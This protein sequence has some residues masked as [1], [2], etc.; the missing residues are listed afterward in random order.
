MPTICK[1]TLDASEYR[2]ELERVVQESRAAAAEMNAIK[3][4]QPAVLPQSNKAAMGAARP[5]VQ[6]QTYTVTGT[7]DAPEAREPVRATADHTPAGATRPEVQDQTYT[8]TGTVNAPE[9][10][11]VQDQTYT[12]TGT[13]N[14]PEVP[15]VQDQTYT[16]S[17]TVNAPEVPDVQDQTYTV[18]GTV[19]APEVPEVPDQTCTVTVTAKDNGVQEV[20]KDTE[21]LGKTLEKIP[22]TKFTDQLKG[23]LSAVREAMNKTSGG[24]EKLLETFF[25]GGGAIGIIIAGFA[26]LGKI[27]MW[28]YGLWTKGAKE[29]SELAQRNAADIRDNAAANEQ[30][31]QAAAG[32]LEKLQSLASQEKL[33]NASKAEAVKLIGDLKKSYGDLG[34]TLDETTGK[35]TGLDA[36]LVKKAQRDK[37]SR[38]SEIKAELKQLQAANKLQTDERDSAGFATGIGNIR[39]GGEEAVQAAQEKINENNKRILELQK[40]LRDAQKDTTPEDLQRQQKARTA[41]KRQEVKEA[42]DARK[43][44]ILDDQFQKAE[45][46]EQ[47]IA[48][49]QKV[50]DELRRQKINPLQQRVSEAKKAYDSAKPEDREEIATRGLELQKQLIAAR[51]EEYA[52][53][54]QIAEVRKRHTDAVR[55]RTRQADFELE[56]QQLILRGE[57]DKA[58]ALKLEKELKEQNLKLTEAEKKAILEKEKAAA[59]QN[60]RTSLHDQAKDLYGQAMERAGRGQEYARTKAL[61]DARRAKGR[62]LTADES[63]MVLQLAKLSSSLENMRGIQLGDISIKTNSLTARGGF[64]GGAKMPDTQKYNRAIASSGKQTAELLKQIKSLLDKLTGDE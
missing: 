31:R 24:A 12:V 43:R 59:G 56:Y 34:I 51:E 11:D 39:L 60:L 8:V 28:A 2:S 1:I 25:A 13:V 21:K 49:R 6:D 58:A 22:A 45:D 37:Q 50:L 30:N 52:L 32:Y 3:A 57:Y 63:A 44:R 18:T 5:E 62:D 17:G 61:E 35:I 29:A 9:I 36:A 64:A 16:V 4:D 53:E 42:F 10:P 23:G 48:N 14:A 55:S 7:V 47:K 15:E 20:T 38:I 19:D 41:D 26:S 27:A 40:A 33:S 54:Q 46:P